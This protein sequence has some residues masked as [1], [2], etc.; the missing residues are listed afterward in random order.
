MGLNRK[1]KRRRMKEQAK[2]TRKAL[3][4]MVNRMNSLGDECSNCSAPFDRSDVEETSKWMVYVIDNKPHL[5]CPDCNEMIKE[6]KS[7]YEEEGDAEV[8]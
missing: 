5:I 8:N 4:N 1:L 2:K 7:D 6:A 3:K